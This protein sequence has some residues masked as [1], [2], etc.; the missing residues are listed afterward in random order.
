M[1]GGLRTCGGRRCSEVQLGHRHL[2]AATNERRAHAHP[3]PIQFVG[4]LKASMVLLVLQLDGLMDVGD[5]VRR[6]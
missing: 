6:G 1:C 5:S 2:A 4:V 3:A